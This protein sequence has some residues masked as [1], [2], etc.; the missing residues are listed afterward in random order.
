MHLKRYILVS[1]LGLFLFQCIPIKNP[2][3]PTGGFNVGTQSFELTDTNRL[4]WFTKDNLEDTRKIMVQVWY[5]TIDTEG[6]KENYIDYGKIRAKALAEQFDYKPFIFNSLIKVKSNSFSNAKADNQNGPYP[7]VIFSHGLGGNRTQNTVIMEELASHGYVVI[8]IEHAYDANVSIFNNE[9]IADYRSGINYERKDEAEDL[10]PED[11]W[12]IRLPQLQTRAAD[13][14]FLI[15]VLSENK[16]SEDILQII[17]LDYI[18]IL[19]HSFGGATSIYS[20]YSDNRINAC[21]NLDGWMVV[22][23]DDIINNGI[24]QNFMYIGQGKWWDELNYNKLDQFIKSNSSSTKVL[25]QGT[26]HYDF[27][28]MPHLTNAG[29]ILGKTGKKIKMDDLK[30]ALNELIISFF[31]KN[32]KNSQ[33]GINYYDFAIKHKISMTSEQFEKN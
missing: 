28:D 30:N 24:K 21:I 7:L 2:P 8:A 12:A 31:N 6:K 27:S 18:G 26:T 1:F 14:S 9:D 19:G 32:L 3:Q 29:N 33:S 13:V 10:T 16:F 15:D 20:A 23:P 5:P 25:I 22:V 17:D 4:E 11:F